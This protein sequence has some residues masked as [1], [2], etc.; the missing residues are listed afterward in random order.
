MT[1]LAMFGSIVSGFLANSV[2]IVGDVLATLLQ[3][4]FTVFPVVLSTLGGYF[5][6]GFHGP[7]G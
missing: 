6:F 5:L 3:E 2:E 7:R 4:S 1:I